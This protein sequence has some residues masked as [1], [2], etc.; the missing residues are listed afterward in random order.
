MLGF[1]LM[2]FGVAADLIAALVAFAT[3]AVLFRK[4]S[5]ASSAIG[6]E[7]S[8]HRFDPCLVFLALPL[9]TDFLGFGRCD[10]CPFHPFRFRE[11]IHSAIPPSTTSPRSIG[12][13][14]PVRAKVSPDGVNCCQQGFRREDFMRF[15]GYA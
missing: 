9:F 7:A 4:A 6:F 12:D 11:S 2:F 3:V 5:Y 1:H 14:S 13:T 15:L 8:L 10:F